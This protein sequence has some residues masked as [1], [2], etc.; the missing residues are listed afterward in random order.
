MILIAQILRVI[1]ALFSIL[2]DKAINIKK[3]FLYNG[4]NNLFCGISYFCMNAITG[5]ISA[6]LALFRNIL[7]YQYKEK[8]TIKEVLLYFVIIIL[9]N[10]SSINGIVSCIPALLVIIYTSALYTKNTLYIKYACIITSLLEIIYDYVYCIYVG[11]FVCVLAIILTSYSIY[12][13][14]NKNSNIVK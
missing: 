13:L 8:V 3:I 6:F 1:A 2:S 7:F 4:I 9:F 11:I 10:I 12:K 5:G 14:D